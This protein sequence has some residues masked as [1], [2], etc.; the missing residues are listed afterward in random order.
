[1]NI[2]GAT[3]IGDIYFTKPTNLNSRNSE[4][5]KLNFHPQIYIPMKNR[6]QNDGIERTFN[7]KSQTEKS[8]QHHTGDIL[9]SIT[10]TRNNTDNKFKVI[11]EQSGITT[12][13]CE[14]SS[15]KMINYLNSRNKDLEQQGQV[16]TQMV[17][18]F[19][20]ENKSL[21]L[22]L[23]L[24]QN[25]N[26]ELS[27]ELNRIDEIA[28]ELKRKLDS[29]EETSEKSENEHKKRKFEFEKI[30][31]E[32]NALISELQKNVER[33]H[34]SLGLIKYESTNKDKT[35]LELKIKL[36]QANSYENANAELQK[37][38]FQVKDDQ[39]HLT[40]MHE[41]E[42][43]KLCLENLELKTTLEKHEKTI[44]LINQKSINY[45]SE[46]NKIENICK[47]SLEFCK[48]IQEGNL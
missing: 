10:T 9:E 16:L 8:N 2:T 27:Q 46:I 24:K 37:K 4:K 45:D 5:N 43:Q 3:H 22:R 34:F 21:A 28:M 29:V 19:R 26:N 33:G 18:E 11:S 20:Q 47:T 30:D 35:I 17:S 1:M 39:K 38:N 12:K 25:H 31:E 44:S 7:H 15:S 41:Q 32:K 23:N 48:D 13:V 42:R 40:L 36:D 6:D 14:N